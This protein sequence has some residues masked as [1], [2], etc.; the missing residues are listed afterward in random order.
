MAS[1]PVSIT[2]TPNNLALVNA[3]AALTSAQLQPL[4]NTISALFPAG[5]SA[6]TI[7]N[8]LPS[9]DNVVINSGFD[10]W[11]NGTTFS[12][13]ST[14][15]V[16]CPDQWIVGNWGGGPN[17]TVS[18]VLA[19]TGFSGQYAINIAAL[20]TITGQNLQL[21]QR[22]ESGAV[23]DFDSKTASFSFDVNASTSAGALSLLFAVY[24]NTALDN[25]TY[26][27]ITAY[28]TVTLPSGTG[29]VTIPL[30]AAQ[31][32]GLKYGC[33]VTLAFAQNA[34]AGIPNITVGGVKFQKGS[35]FTPWASKG[36]A[37]EW[38][39]CE[40][41]F[42]TSYDVGVVPGTVGST[43]YMRFTEGTTTYATLP[44]AYRTRM[45]A[46]PSVLLY[47]PN[48][49]ATGKL[50]NYSGATDVAASLLYGTSISVG[51]VAVANNVS[52]GSGSTIG[53][54]WTANARL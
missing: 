12:L 54:H 11:Q 18:R 43:G 16:Y 49:G 50:Y 2:I 17:I 19:P 28:I 35:I 13:G 21:S 44:V 40:R 1:T 31:T 48:S 34:V 15:S 23:A 5:G 6:Q 38:R 24:A 22:F 25:G 41:F 37:C 52:I 36:I 42:Q 8:A 33:Q 20:G 10:V 29:R 27:N 14:A 45:R 9:S 51:F 47:S 30:T 7:G 4:A 53:I 3:A 32:V 26:S 39:D 46:S